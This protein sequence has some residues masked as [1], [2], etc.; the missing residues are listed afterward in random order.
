MVPSQ[1]RS[2]R[3]LTQALRQVVEQGFGLESLQPKLAERN[4]GLPVAFLDPRLIPIPLLVT[5]QSWTPR[6]SGIDEEAL[7]RAHPELVTAKDL[8]SSGRLTQII[9]GEAPLYT[10]LPPIH[11]EAYLDGLRPGAKKELH[12]QHFSALE[13]LATFGWKRFRQ[14]RA[15]GKDLDR[16]QPEPDETV[17]AVLQTVTPPHNPL[18]LVLVVLRTEPHPA[19]NRA[20]TAA[21]GENTF[22]ENILGWNQVIHGLLGDLDSVWSALPSANEALVSFCHSDDRLAPEAPQLLSQAAEASPTAALFSSD[23]TLQWSSEPAQRPGNRQNRVAAV[24]WRLLTR[25]CIGGL[26]TIRLSRLRQL[27]LPKQRL[28][29]HNL[30]LDLS[31]QVSTQSQKC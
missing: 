7:G 15:L 25:G 2:D 26:V 22:G 28:C 24:P 8:V 19:D 5:P 9:R 29:I 16:Y 6:D 12:R 4:P 30:V 14:G 13:H 31:L 17:H 10:D 23:E 3:S 27:E 21:D 11:L 18:P 20:T 1:R